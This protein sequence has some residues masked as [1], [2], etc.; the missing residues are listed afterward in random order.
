MCLCV[1][2]MCWYSG[3]NRQGFGGS[4]SYMLLIVAYIKFKADV[5]TGST[6]KRRRSNRKIDAEQLERNNAMLNG[7]TFGYILEGVVRPIQGLISTNFRIKHLVLGLAR[8]TR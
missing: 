2:F 3:L 6:T 5:L 8:L 4:A 7:L 1:C